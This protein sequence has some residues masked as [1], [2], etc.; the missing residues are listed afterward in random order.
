MTSSAGCGWPIGRRIRTNIPGDS[1]RMPVGG[2]G[3][4]KTPR[5]EML[6]VVGL[7][8]LLTKLIVP[9]VREAVLALQAHQDRDQAVL[10]L[11]DL[12]LVDRLRIRSR[13]GSSTSK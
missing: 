4:G 3:L 7:T 13:V 11:L 6:P 8:W 12:P 2:L 1:S 9:L 5:T 10:R